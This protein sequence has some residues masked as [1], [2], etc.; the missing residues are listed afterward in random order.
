MLKHGKF[1]GFDSKTQQKFVG[2]DSKALKKDICIVWILKDGKFYSF[3]SK[4]L[5]KFLV[6]KFTQFF[7]TLMDKMGKHTEEIL[8]NLNNL[9]SQH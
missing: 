5:K 8:N 2:L 6:H 9:N 4:R 3:D 1:P 7:R